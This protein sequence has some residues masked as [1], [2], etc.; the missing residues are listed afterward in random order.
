MSC[1]DCTT[2]AQRMHHGFSAGCKGCA[3][4]AVSRGPNYRRARDSGRQDWKYRAELE[5]LG[6]TH[7][8]VREAARVDALGK[9]AA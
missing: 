5:N 3:A 6:V 4:R 7:E 2:A 8:Q 9:E 1:P